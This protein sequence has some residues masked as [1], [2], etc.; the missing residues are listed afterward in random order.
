[1]N[2]D[3]NNFTKAPYGGGKIFFDKKCDFHKHLH[4]WYRT[5]RFPYYKNVVTF[6]AAN[7]DVNICFTLDDSIKPFCKIDQGY[8][9]HMDSYIAF[10]KAISIST[11]GRIRAFLSQNLN[12]KDISAT[13]TDKD[14][15]IKANA[16]QK[17]IL[18]A[19]ENLAPDAKKSISDSLK[20]LQDLPTSTISE[21]NDV[22]VPE[23]LNAFSQ[24]L[25]NK[26]VQTA[27]IRNIPQVQIEVLKKHIE[28]L[29]ANLDKNE[30]F[31]QNW[32]DIDDGKYRKQRCLIFGI[33]YIDPKREGRLSGKR[34]DV[35]AEQNRNYHVIIE[36]KSPSATVFDINSRDNPN[37][38]KIEDYSISRELSR[39][40][41]QIL[42]YKKWYMKASAEEIQ[43]LGIKGKKEISQCIIVIGQDVETPVWRDNFNDLRKTLNGVDIW[44]YTHLINKLENTVH[45]LQEAL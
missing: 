36:L 13:Q 31:I 44:T 27:F 43:E 37:G 42:G 34:F 23:F 10:C 38:G 8:L 14:E 15:Y 35:L 16:T 12:L 24:F 9:V 1:M 40:I 11:E 21:G 41:P 19:I 30:T 7:P 32:I 20:H 6:V 2:I 45:N 22:T 3:L 29:K 33:E 28:F 25:A 4:H 39:A 5:S 17:N 26:D 18:A